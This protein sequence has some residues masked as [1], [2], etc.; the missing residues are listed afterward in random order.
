MHSRRGGITESKAHAIFARLRDDILHGRL[1][2]GDTLPGSRRIAAKT[3]VAR[4]TI[5][6]AYAMLSAEGLIEIPPRGNPR[7]RVS[8]PVPKRKSPARIRLT[9]WARSL[10][11][12]PT[13][14][15]GAAFVTGKLADEFFPER[16]W[17]ASLGVA[18][19]AFAVRHEDSV[20][21]SH[22]LRRAIADHLR[23]SRGFTAHPEQIV[24]TNGS[25]QAITL[26]AQ[27]LLDADS[28]AAV[29]N[30]G[31]HGIRAAIISTGARAVYC[32]LDSEGMQTPRTKCRVI[33]VT[34]ASQFP[35]GIRM[36]HTRRNDLL[37]Y[38]ATH[39]NIIVEDE[40]DSEFTRLKNPPPALKLNDSDDRVVYIGSFSRTMFHALRIGY[41]VLPEA[42]VDTFLRARRLYDTVAPQQNEQAAMAHF[43]RSGGYRRHLRRMNTVY[44]ERH[45]AL[46]S[47][48]A[49]KLTVFF[50]PMPSAAG[51]SICARWRASPADVSRAAAA[52]MN[53]GCGWQNA[54]PYFAAKGESIGI[55]GFGGL[56]PV[57]LKNAIT[58]LDRVLQQIF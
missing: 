43:M 58:R 42:L 48:F 26:L 34:P 56:T 57:Q 14:D 32:A 51:L 33:F 23:I 31:F 7:V 2:S 30:P 37:Q 9:R 45:D 12:L 5:N 6:I 46:L 47:G 20:A 41:C 13:A 53:A 44:N 21:G 22:E 25:M 1:R 40:Y 17:L 18:R 49:E 39:S 35:T 4:G 28:L 29:E 52:A 55:F 8:L 54:R 19:R 36:S 16:E 27:L 3:G 11:P 15:N 50:D 38:A 10:P 24:V